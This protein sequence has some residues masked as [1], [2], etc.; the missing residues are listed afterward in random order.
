[1]VP[2]VSNHE[3]QNRN[4]VSM[5]VETSH[6]FRIRVLVPQS[7]VSGYKIDEYLK[8]QSKVRAVKHVFRQLAN[9]RLVLSLRFSLHLAAANEIFVRAYVA[10]QCSHEQRR[11]Q[12]ATSSGVFVLK[13]PCIRS[14]VFS[15]CHRVS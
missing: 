14:M 9:M 6:A 3:M 11:E 13:Q 15:M 4:S 2:P 1:M 7:Q 12:G 8:R 10:A 5:S